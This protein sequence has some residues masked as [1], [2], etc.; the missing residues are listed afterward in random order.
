[1]NTEP[2]TNRCPKCQ[3]PLPANA[4]QGLCPKCLLAAVSTPTEAG[5]PPDK[6]PPPPIEAVA[7]AF[8]QL[9]ILELIGQGGMGVV[10]KARQPQARPL[11]R[12]EAPAAIAGRRP[13]LRRAVQPRG[14]RAGAAQP[15]EHRHRPRL[16]PVRRLLLPA[17]GVRGRREPAPGHAGGPLH[18]RSRRCAR[19]ED[20][21]GAP[22]R[23]RRRHP[24]PRHQAG[25]HPARH[26]RAG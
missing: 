2:I 16:R 19:A 23:P 14:P 22:V 9:E 15:P 20:L 17:D 3:A 11:R 13:R 10:Y 6:N 12:A 8:P 4:P 26:A 5:Q 25:E 24:A 7:A 18:A 21:R 1:M